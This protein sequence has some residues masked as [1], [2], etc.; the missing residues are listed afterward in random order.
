MLHYTIETYHKHLRMNME[1]GLAEEL[2]MVPELQ[3]SS[4]CRNVTTS[5]VFFPYSELFERK[6]LNWAIFVWPS[7]V[8]ST[9]FSCK[10]I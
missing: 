2:C 4:W 7:Y 10:G 5:E 1:D 8:V 6:F 9:C 3:L